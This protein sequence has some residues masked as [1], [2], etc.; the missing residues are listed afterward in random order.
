MLYLVGTLI[1]DVFYNFQ[2]MTSDVFLVVVVAS[3]LRIET[4]SPTDFTALSIALQ[5]VLLILFGILKTLARIIVD[6]IDVG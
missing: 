2:L 4:I 6:Y 5:I 1:D 3:Y